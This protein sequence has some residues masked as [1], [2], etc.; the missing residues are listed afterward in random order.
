MTMQHKYA[1]INSIIDNKYSRLYQQFY[2]SSKSPWSDQNLTEKCHFTSLCQYGNI[3]WNPTESRIQDHEFNQKK[4]KIQDHE[5][6]DFEN[7][8][9]RFEI[10]KY[11]YVS[12]SSSVLVNIWFRI[13]I[14]A[15]FTMLFIFVIIY[16]LIIFLYYL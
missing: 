3:K 2:D 7:P 8:Q 10:L 16:D 15:Y 6:P 4:K 12:F 1:I 14:S 9:I 11:I 5:W 13:K